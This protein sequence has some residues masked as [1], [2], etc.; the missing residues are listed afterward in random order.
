MLTALP[1]VRVPWWLVALY[2]LITQWLFHGSWN[3]HIQPPSP[4]P[5][6]C[7]PFL[8][9]WSKDEASLLLR[10]LNSLP[11]STGCLTRSFPA[12]ASAWSPHL[13]PHIRNCPPIRSAID[14]LDLRRRITETVVAAFRFGLRRCATELGIPTPQ[15][16]HEVKSALGDT[17]GSRLSTNVLFL[18]LPLSRYGYGVLDTVSATVLQPFSLSS[19]SPLLSFPTPFTLPYPFCMFS[20]PA[21]LRLLLR[22]QPQDVLSSYIDFVDSRVPAS[23]R[24]TVS[25]R[26]TCHR[27]TQAL[28][29]EVGGSGV[30]PLLY[31]Y[32]IYIRYIYIY[33]TI[34]MTPAR[35]PKQLF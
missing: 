33:T 12:R 29:R 4:T 16:W 18:A 21:L 22:S 30:S 15:L 10:P 25:P 3:G 2:T 23:Q 31:I 32:Y 1:I 35:V 19:P 20:A 7:S 27:V 28:G 34:Y 6:T 17:F 8:P 26:Q 5:V 24:A 11:R 14:L 13:F 9:R